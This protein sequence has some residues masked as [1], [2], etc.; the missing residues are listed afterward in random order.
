MKETEITMLKKEVS[1]K[2]P[3]Q[4]LG[5]L[6]MTAANPGPVDVPTKTFCWFPQSNI[7]KLRF[8]RGQAKLTSTE[9][10]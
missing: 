4:N 2:K 5:R 9:N 3:I 10:C 1:E 8:S 7:N 6:E